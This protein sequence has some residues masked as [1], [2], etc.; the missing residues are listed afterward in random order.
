MQH[1][2]FR[3]LIA[4]ALLAPC[5]APSAAAQGVPPNTTQLDSI[6]THLL[7]AGRAVGG[8]VAVFRDTSTLLLKAY[9][10]ADAARGVSM[11]VDAIFEV[12]S[13]TKQ[14]TAAA[15]LKLRDEARL[16]LED[17]IRKWL[18]D[19]DTRGD[20]ITIRHL[21]NHT[22]GIM[23][24]TEMPEFA[25][26]ATNDRYP[27]DSA[28]ALIKRYPMQFRPGTIQVYN[29]SAYFLLGLIIE[30]A[31]GMSYAQF[32]ER[33]LFAPLGM[34]HSA[35]CS[36]AMPAGPRANGHTVQGNTV[37]AARKNVHTWPFAAGSICSTAGDLMKWLQA[38]HGGR[39]LSSRS[40][41]EMAS[42]ARLSDG[43]AVRYGLGVALGKDSRGS[44]FVGHGGTIEG[45][46]S[47][48]IWY[49]DA[50][51]GVIVLLN[52]YGSISPAVIAEE[53]AGHLSQARAAAPLRFSGDAG[54]LLGT[55]RGISRGRDMVVAVNQGP[56]GAV[57]FSVNGSPPRVLPWVGG[58]TFQGGAA[59]LTFEQTAGAPAATALRF[60]AGR[61]GYYIL[62]RQ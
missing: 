16:A 59:L 35:Y 32:V 62:K 39:V 45:F 48:T 54:A 19:F 30:K 4:L 58:L 5:L 46:T 24:L 37:Q 12:G 1:R 34:T 20:T 8:V 23:G 60:D 57:A 40:Y 7:T 26:L 15:V 53:L 61:G 28:Y 10:S 22:S 55:Y 36:D 17:D 11:P 41:A 18:P 49:P 9:G 56:E 14:F 47:E 43:T 3:S 13:V 6:A 25:A 38:L 44:S 31:S 21:L 52:S 33:K 29:N 27:R 51:V 50:R 2:F 42:P